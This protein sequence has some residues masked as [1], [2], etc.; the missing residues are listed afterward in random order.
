MPDQ[1]ENITNIEAV[2]DK[3]ATDAMYNVAKVPYHEHTGVDSPF[4]DASSLTG[5]VVAWSKRIYAAD[6]AA[7]DAYTVALNP[8]PAAYFVGL[9]VNFKAATANTGASTLNVNSL[10][11][12]A[13]KKL[14]GSTD[15]ATGDIVVGQIVTVVYD[16]T[17]FQMQSVIASGGA[18]F[19]TNYVFGN[20]TDV[21]QAPDGATVN[22]DFTVTTTFTPTLIKL[23]FF[24]QGWKNSTA[25]YFGAKGIA[26]Y[27]GTTL[28]SWYPIWTGS[29]VNLGTVIT[30][31]NGTPSGAI[32]AVLANQAIIT[33][34]PAAGQNIA[35]SVQTVLTINSVSSTNFVIRVAS[36]GGAGNTSNSRASVYYEA[37]A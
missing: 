17:N 13:I 20:M 22:T 36:K 12:I 6:T 30:G 34:A 18:A 35:T 14:G 16:G 1:T 31:D 29:D 19:N 5:L 15:T 32:S 25:Q 11:A 8:S 23:Y 9:T 10:G 2:V 27:T 37:W 26:S 24:V 21:V 33:N 3:S 28:V 7:T 4:V